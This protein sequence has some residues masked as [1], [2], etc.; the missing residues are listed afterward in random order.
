MHEIGIDQEIERTIDGG[1]R[2]FFTVPFQAVENIVSTDRFMTVP[3]QAQDLLTQRGK[4]QA[5][6]ATQFFGRFQRLR[7][8]DAVIVP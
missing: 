6:F 1:R 3:D 7:Y 4:S 2:G 8:A 5:T